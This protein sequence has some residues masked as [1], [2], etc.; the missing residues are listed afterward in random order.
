[1]GNAPSALEGEMRY[2]ER[3]LGPSLEV[4]AVWP[5]NSTGIGREGC[6]P[7][8]IG[9]VKNADSDLVILGKAAGIFACFH[10]KCA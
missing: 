3:F 5:S 10:G 4:G 1:M 8:E 7:M 9:R 2:E 6:V